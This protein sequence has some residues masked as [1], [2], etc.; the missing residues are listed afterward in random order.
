MKK[1]HFD[2]PFDI[3]LVDAPLSGL[4]KNSRYPAVPL[5]REF[6]AD[7][8]VVFLDDIE[9]P[10]ETEIAE[11]WCSEFELSYQKLGI[12][13]GLGIMRPKNS[14]DKFNIH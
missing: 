12:I 14:P 9:R 7:D 2:A 11:E 1:N 6:L 13:G 10:D 4:C 3:L 8:F 5:L